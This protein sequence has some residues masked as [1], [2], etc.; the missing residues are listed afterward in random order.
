[1]IDDI[2]VGVLKVGGGDLVGRWGDEE[3]GESNGFIC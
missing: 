3:K 1:M 2:P